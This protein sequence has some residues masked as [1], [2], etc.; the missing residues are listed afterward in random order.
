[1]D[2]ATAL[3]KAHAYIAKAKEVGVIIT[4]SAQEDDQPLDPDMDPSCHE[5]VR[6]Q[7]AK[8]N[9]LWSWADV[10]VTAKF[11]G[12]EASDYLS[13]CMYESEEDFKNPEGYYTDMCVTAIENLRAKLAKCAES[14]QLLQKAFVTRYT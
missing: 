12:V 14:H 4:L 9:D 5:W 7:R 2:L 13:G 11:G 8:G 10:T 1:M 3:V 6:E